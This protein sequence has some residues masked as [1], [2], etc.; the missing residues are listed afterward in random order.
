[1]FPVQRVYPLQ[2]SLLLLIVCSR[3]G[4]GGDCL[5]LVLQDFRAKRCNREVTGHHPVQLGEARFYQKYPFMASP[6]YCVFSVDVVSRLYAGGGRC[7]SILQDQTRLLTASSVGDSC[8][9]GT[10]RNSMLESSVCMLWSMEKR[11]QSKVSAS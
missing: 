3:L 8:S 4:W 7:M 11:E 5:L 10:A 9:V 2:F 6:V 1:M